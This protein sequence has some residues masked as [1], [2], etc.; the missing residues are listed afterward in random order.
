ME[1]SVVREPYYKGKKESPH[2]F[3]YKLKFG[4]MTK[5][6]FALKRAGSELYH[7]EVKHEHAVNPNL[8]S[9]LIIELFKKPLYERKDFGFPKG[10]IYSVIEYI[11]QEHGELVL[12]TATDTQ[13]TILKKID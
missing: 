11:P 4:N 10:L 3:P 1:Y 2:R 12:F 5:L 13:E 6:S 9:I 8:L 7:L